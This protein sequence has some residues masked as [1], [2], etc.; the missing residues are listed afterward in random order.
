M[1]RFLI[2]H[3]R[4]DCDP[5]DTAC[6][7]REA[8]LQDELSKLKEKFIWIVSHLQIMI[9]VRSSFYF[10]FKHWSRNGFVGSHRNHV[11]R[12][13]HLGLMPSSC[14]FEILNI[15]TRKST[16]SFCSGLHKF[17]GQFCMGEPLEVQEKM[18][19][20]MLKWWNWLQNLHYPLPTL[21]TY[22]TNKALLIWV[23][24]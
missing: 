12:A 22:Y 18:I 8:R 6:L 24:G 14:H 1:S 21:I 13:L 17:C 15:W 9:K 7:A 19:A 2:N 23:W 16:F 3:V 4:S 10:L 5:W 11:R 20:M